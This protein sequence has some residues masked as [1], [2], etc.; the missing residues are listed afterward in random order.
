MKHFLLTHSG[1]KCRHTGLDTPANS[2]V[3]N[4]DRAAW[5]VTRWLGAGAADA[6]LRELSPADTAQSFLSVCRNWLV[7]LIR[8]EKPNFQLLATRAPSVPT[9]V[10]RTSVAQYLQ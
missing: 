10:H 3:F 6:T 4:E 7:A 8:S 5:A 2:L 9:N 1:F